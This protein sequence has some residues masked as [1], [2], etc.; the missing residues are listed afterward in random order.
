MDRRWM[1]LL[2]LLLMDDNDDDDDDEENN[3]NHQQQIK[4]LWWWASRPYI[5]INR[6]ANATLHLL[7][8]HWWNDGM[9]E[10]MNHWTKSNLSNGPY[11]LL[12]VTGAVVSG[13]FIDNGH[14]AWWWHCHY[15]PAQQHS[16]GSTLVVVLVAAEMSW[17]LFAHVVFFSALQHVHK[18]NAHK[19]IKTP[20]VS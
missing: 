16:I 1:L 10:W 5:I 8:I 11:T 18:H 7:R 4:K 14:S 6:K 13:P 19:N 2:L 15:H 3:N 20:T 17:L 12:L 9:M